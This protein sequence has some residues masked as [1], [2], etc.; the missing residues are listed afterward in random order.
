V[1]SYEITYL[2][3]IALSEK[4]NKREFDLPGS[5]GREGRDEPGSLAFNGGRLGGRW[6]SRRNTGPRTCTA[7][8]GQWQDSGAIDLHAPI[9]SEALTGP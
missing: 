6:Q 7:A 2:H 4:F 1:P 9:V 5:S 8:E 3:D